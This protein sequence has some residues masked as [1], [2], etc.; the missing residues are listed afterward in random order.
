MICSIVFILGPA[1]HV[2]S[3]NSV[4]LAHAK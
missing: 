4:S 3:M 1:E 2:Y